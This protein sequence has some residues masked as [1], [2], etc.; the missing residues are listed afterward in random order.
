LAGETADRISVAKALGR[1]DHHLLP[2]QPQWIVVDAD[3]QM[4]TPWETIT[5]K[6]GITLAR[7]EELTDDADARRDREVSCFVVGDTGRAAKIN[8]PG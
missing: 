3:A 6:T 8:Q 4:C 7:I 1:I 2:S 5:R